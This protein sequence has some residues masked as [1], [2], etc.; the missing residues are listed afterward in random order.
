MAMPPAALTAAISCS[1]PASSGFPAASRAPVSDSV[2]PI[3][4][5]APE[6]AGVPPELGDSAPLPLVQAATASASGT[7]SASAVSNLGRVLNRSS[8]RWR[9][10]VSSPLAALLRPRTAARA[11]RRSRR[12]RS[13]TWCRSRCCQARRLPSARPAGCRR[14]GA[15]DQVQRVV[16]VHPGAGRL[17][18]RRQTVRS[19]QVRGPDVGRRR[20][21]RRRWRARRPP[22]RCRTATIRTTGPQNCSVKIFIDGSTSAS[23][24][25]ARKLPSGS[26]AGRRPPAASRAPSRTPSR[27]RAASESWCALSGSGPSSV[28]G[29]DGSP[30]RMRSARWARR[31]TTAS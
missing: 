24:V 16:G 10:R 5:A 6:L 9:R 2:A 1:Y 22:R 19:L 31:L 18:G 11:C 25:G 28:A 3:T 13:G 21:S 30:T 7:A 17:D 15:C 12:A 26:P 8:S 23:T 20:T 27:T 14:S 4:I 29:S